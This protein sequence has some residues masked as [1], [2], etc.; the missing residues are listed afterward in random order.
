MSEKS[1]KHLVLRTYER[2]ELSGS[3]I[4]ADKYITRTHNLAGHPFVVFCTN[5]ECMHFIDGEGALPHWSEDC[6]ERLGVLRCPAC[7]APVVRPHLP[8]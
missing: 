5:S 2:Q 6:P 7:G 4:P 3:G 1:G 8:S